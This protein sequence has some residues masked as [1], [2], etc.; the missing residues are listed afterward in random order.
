MEALTVPPLPSM[1][2]KRVTT[3]GGV[4]QL[5]TKSSTDLLP[6]EMRI[7]T[8]K[9]AQPAAIVK[10]RQVQRLEVPGEPT[11]RKSSTD[12]EHQR[13]AAEMHFEATTVV[14]GGIYIRCALNDME[15]FAQLSTA[16]LKSGVPTEKAKLHGV[17]RNVKTNNGRQTAALRLGPMLLQ[18]PFEIL[19]N[20]DSKALPVIGIDVLR[21]CR[22]VIDMDRSLLT[23][24]GDLGGAIPLL[25]EDDVFHDSRLVRSKSSLI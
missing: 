19:E 24:G 11:R 14:E 9:D 13:R 1:G 12:I 8:S 4:P 17:S 23:I 3:R 22:C 10:Q 18:T 7:G 2:R 6:I 16:S 25:S 15:T 21:R 20:N 5:T